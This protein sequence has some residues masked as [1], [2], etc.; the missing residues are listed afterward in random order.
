V[1]IA[2]DATLARITWVKMVAAGGWSLPVILH[3]AQLRA[4]F[5]LDHAG[6][7]GDIFIDAIML[8]F[9]RIAT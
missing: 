4:W 1:Y 2:T 6:T 3:A 9:R 7:L 5:N 8:T